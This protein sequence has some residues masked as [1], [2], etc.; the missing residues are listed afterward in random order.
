MSRREQ[1]E[2][3]LRDEPNDLFL[4]YGLA[5]EYRKEAIMPKVCAA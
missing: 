4:R 2:A 5:M 1:I 3:M